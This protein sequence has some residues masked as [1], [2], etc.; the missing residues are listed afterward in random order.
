MIVETDASDKGCG[1]I[2]K[3]RKNP[4]LSEQLVRYTSG[5]RNSAQMNYSTIN[6]ELLSIATSLNSKMIILINNSCLK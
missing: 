6:K 3:Q 4:N 2:F 5:F 1:G